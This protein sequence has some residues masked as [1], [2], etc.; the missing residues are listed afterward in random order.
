MLYL[1]QRNLTS[2]ES[3]PTNEWGVFTS[4]LEIGDHRYVERQVD[5][6]ANG[7][8]LRY[9]RHHW[10]DAFG[11]LA[12]AKYDE[13]KWV[14]YWGPS[15]EIHLAEFERAWQLAGDTT[16]H[17]LQLGS[18]QCDEPAPWIPGDES[19]LSDDGTP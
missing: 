11:L 14:K 1:K 16:T 18:R 13:E 6:F 15:E 8:G 10:I 2:H 9:H 5:L 3:L 12:D 17:Q 4:Y 19:R 7:N